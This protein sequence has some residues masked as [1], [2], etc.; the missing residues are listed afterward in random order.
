M[1]IERREPTLGGGVETPEPIAHEPA[2]RPKRVA[3]RPVSQSNSGSAMAWFAFLLA[4]VGLSASG[5]IYWQAQQYR[6]QANTALID[7]D[8]R[9]ALL[10][11]RLDFTD[12]ESSQSVESIRV[13]LKWADSEIRKLWGVANDRNRKAIAAQ[14]NQISSLNK[15]LA[16]AAANAK[17]ATAKGS[18]NAKLIAGLDQQL[19][20]QLK[21]QAEAVQTLAQAEAGLQ[22]QGASLDRLLKDVKA[23]AITLDQLKNGLLERVQMNE[24]ALESITIYRKTTNRE[25]LNIKKRLAGL[26]AKPAP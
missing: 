16:T 14:K 9:L 3:P 12:E 18:G 26:S 24:D 7:A 19:Q 1:S 5:Y 2:A 15:K 23:Q 10:E 21:A 6:L 25:L 13:K 8:S 20:S 22:A 17:N 11:K 4:V